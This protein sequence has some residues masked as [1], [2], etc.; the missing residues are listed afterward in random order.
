VYVNGA[1]VRALSGLETRLADGDELAIVPA[2]AGGRHAGPA[3]TR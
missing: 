3:D 1:D 2:I